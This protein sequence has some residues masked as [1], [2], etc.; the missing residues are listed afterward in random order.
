VGRGRSQAASR[1]LPG[2]QLGIGGL[3]VCERL[4]PH[5]LA[6]AKHAERLSVVEQQ[7]GWLLGRA[8]AYLRGRGQYQEARPVAERA[9]RVTEQALGPDHPEVGERCDELGQML[10]EAGDYRSARQQ[11][12]RALVIH[13]AAYGPDHAEVASRHNDRA[14]PLPMT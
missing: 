6:S 11:L 1:Q 9:L 2:G 7:A 4:L 8:S 13:Q 12:E 3:A 14:S 5:V 10:R